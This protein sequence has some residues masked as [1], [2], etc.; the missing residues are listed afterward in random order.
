MPP[1]ASKTE[2]GDSGTDKPERTG[3]LQTW[4]SA[5]RRR[6]ARRCMIWTVLVVVA[7]VGTVSGLRR[8]ERNILDVPRETARQPVRIRLADCPDWMPQRLIREIADQLGP[9]S[10]DY[11]EVDLARQVYQAAGGHPWIRKVE[12]AFKAGRDTSGV[13]IVELRAEYRM[14]IAWV[15]AADG[16]C[17]AVDVQGYVLPPGQVPQWVVR[18]DGREISYINTLDIPA[19]RQGRQIHY[20]TITGV[21]ERSPGVGRQWPGSRITDGLKLARLMYARPYATQI[22]VIDVRDPARLRMYAQV[23]TSRRTK[24]EFGRLPVAGCDYNVSTA[25]KIKKL[26][27]VAALHGGMLA[28]LKDL[29]LQLDGVYV[30]TQ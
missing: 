22:N 23:G 2:S 18:A 16:H 14:P 1:K 20:I 11:R 26:D 3:R 12:L 10:G 30:S 13:G 28:G 7:V 6:V 21:T 29:N 24:I 8:L 9:A 4:L 25:N 5:D 19:G 17:R 27:G 15:L